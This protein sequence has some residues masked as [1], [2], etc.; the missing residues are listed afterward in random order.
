MSTIKLRVSHI[1]SLIRSRQNTLE[2]VSGDEGPPPPQV[3]VAEDS[4]RFLTG[5]FRALRE[6]GKIR[7]FLENTVKRRAGESREFRNADGQF[8][9]GRSSFLRQ[10]N[11]GIGK[12]LKRRRVFGV[13]SCA[14]AARQLVRNYRARAASGSPRQQQRVATVLSLSRPSRLRAEAAT[15]NPGIPG[16]F[17]EI[18]GLFPGILGIS[19]EFL[20]NF[21]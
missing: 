20:E 3:D 14:A 1:A 15:C 7:G 17:P 13:V 9:G 2:S 21:L 4:P 8:R 10:R 11:T 18:P 5:E 19:R 12:A 6:Q 16:I